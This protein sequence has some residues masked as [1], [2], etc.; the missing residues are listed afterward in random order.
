MKPVINHSP[1]VIQ[2]VRRQRIV[3]AAITC[4]AR[5]GWHGSTLATVAA[6]ANISRGLISYHFSGRDDLFEVVLETVVKVIFE[7]G[8]AQMNEKIDQVESATAKLEAYIKEN[9]RF[10]GE[11]RR[12][13]AALNEIMP[14]L[15]TKNGTL[16]FGGDADEHAVAGTALLFDYGVKTGEFRKANSQQLAFMLRQCIDGAARKVTQD[17]SFNHEAYAEQLLTLLLKGVAK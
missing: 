10:I 5:D 17:A 4:L 11:H 7:N 9:L 12:E 3:D 16:R 13:M 8:A 15:R 6:E 14:N 1:T 2:E